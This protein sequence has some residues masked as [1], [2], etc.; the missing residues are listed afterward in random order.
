MKKLSVVI[1]DFKSEYLEKQNFN[2]CSLDIE[3]N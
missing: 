1:P 3:D 2:F